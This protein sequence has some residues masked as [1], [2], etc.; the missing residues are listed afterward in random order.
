[1]G[2]RKGHSHAQNFLA[3]FFK[4]HMA[5]MN[6]SKLSN[7]SLMDMSNPSNKIP[8]TAPEPRAGSRPQSLWLQSSAT[9]L[10]EKYLISR[11][12]KSKSFPFW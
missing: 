4:L 1:M 5:T 12:T 3:R 11:L 10:G 7:M 6:D 2:I 9:L 8:V